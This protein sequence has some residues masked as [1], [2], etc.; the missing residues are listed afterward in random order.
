[1]LAQAAELALLDTQSA[2]FRSCIDTL[3]V[4]RSHADTSPRF[5]HKFG[6]SKNPPRSVANRLNISPKRNI[7][8][9]YS[10][11][12]PQYAVNWAAE[13]IANREI[14]TV[15]ITGGEVLKTQLFAQRES[16]DLNW[17][18]D[19]RGAPELLGDSRTAWTNHEFDHGLKSA[20][21]I[22]PLF[23]NAIRRSRSSSIDSHMGSMAKIMSGLSKVAANN[24]NAVRPHFYTAERLA[25]IDEENR[26]ISFPYSRLMVS[27]AFIDQAGSFI[28]TSVENAEKKGIPREKWVF[29][30]GYSDANDH[31]FV[32]EKPDLFS[33]PAIRSASKSALKMADKNI[34]DVHHFDIYSCF[35]SA[36]EISCKELGIAEDD[37]RGLTVTG[38]LPYY[39][40]AGN[41]YVVMSIC[42]MVKKLRANTGEFGLVTANGN[43]IS[44]HS[45]GIYSTQPVKGK[46]QK[47]DC[48]ALQEE[49]DASPKADFT[50]HP[51]GPSKVITYGINFNKRGPES[52]TIIGEELRSGRRFISLLHDDCLDGSEKV[53]WLDAKGVVN[54]QK[55]LNIF[56]PN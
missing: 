26:W 33:S 3:V 32:T 46:W 44:K 8:T 29:L 22:Y 48:G 41:S 51:S 20:I 25:T 53:D 56:T 9:W 5:A 6:G 28:V 31:W 45:F 34:D 40:G 39:G 18:E 24:E 19:P 15:L 13:R 50:E 27:N 16:V 11:N 36:V 4:I 23:E 43:W 35:P 10:G 7:Y 37:P 49:I 38:G 42:E 17:N 30:H 1:L 55:G 2:D 21:S 54:K 14:D 47:N 12:M 52:A